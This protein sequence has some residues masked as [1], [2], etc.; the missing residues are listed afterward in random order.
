MYYYCEGFAKCKKLCI[1]TINYDVS[2]TAHK[3]QIRLS[4]DQHN[5]ISHKVI[6]P[7]IKEKV[8]S[9]LSEGTYNYKQIKKLINRE[10]IELTNKQLYWIANRHKQLI[11]DD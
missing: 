1:V 7:H 4:S 11:A 9:L 5:H 8:F 3:Y 10:N 2:K 6:K